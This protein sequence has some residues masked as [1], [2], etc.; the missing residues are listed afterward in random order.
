MHGLNNMAKQIPQNKFLKQSNYGTTLGDTIESFN[1]DLNSNY[2]AIRGTRMKKIIDSTTSADI[3]IPVAFAF[4][5]F[6]YRFITD[7]FLYNGGANISDTFTKDASSGAPNG[8]LSESSSDMKVF[9]NCLYVSGSDEVMKLNLTTW[10]TPITSGLTAARPHLLEAF[11]NKLYITDEYYKVHSITTADTLNTTGTGTLDLG[12]DNSWTITML[13][14]GLDSIWIGLVNSENGK[15]LVYEWDGETENIPTRKIE[16]E[17]GVASG[18][19]L[20]NVPYVL[21]IRGKLLRYSG[22]GFT[23]IDR[24]FLKSNIALDESNSLTNLRFIHPNGMTITDYGTIL[25]LIRNTKE[26]SLGFEDTIPSGIYEYDPQIGLYH[27][28][29]ISY[30]PTGATTVTDYGQQRL[31]NVGAIFFRRP[32]LP[33]SGE[34]GILLAGAQ[35]FTNATTTAYGVFCDDTLDTTQKYSYFIT[36]KLFADQIEDTWQKIY[37]IYKKLLASSDKIVLKY[38]TEEDSAI[39]ATITWTSTSSFTTTTDLSA[40]SKGDEVQV[41]QGTGAGKLAHIAT[42][43]LNTGTY[44][45]TLDDTFAGATGTA[46]ALVSKWIKLGEA[47]FDESK[48]SKGMTLNTKNVSPWVQ[49]KIGMQLTGKNELYKLRVINK[50][51]INE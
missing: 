17:A 13:K 41:I 2:G 21:D 26:N 35:Y 3:E 5:N 20:N 19:V 42:I 47:T 25:F 29:S 44:T 40:Y 14:A 16:L 18:I 4:Y 24:L 34:N 36:S 22:T 6:K 30:S 45:V 27:K 39:E 28:M 31:N 9:N 51:N 33:T 43:S 10:S 1:L 48:Q 38:R 46:K 11:G 50:T 23:E 8:E 32:I 7:D 37:S 49:F 12:L 15:G